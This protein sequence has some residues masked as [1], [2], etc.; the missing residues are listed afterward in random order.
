MDKGTALSR[1]E[2]LELVRQYKHIIARHFQQEPRVLMY[3]SYSKGNAN[4]DSD[5]DVAVVV[6]S[7]G[8]RK[9][10]LSKALWRDVD[11]VSLLIEPVLISEDHPSPLYDDVMRTGIAV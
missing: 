6:S 3:G 9:L 11:N 2:A 8:D 10:E 4:R 5:I 1:D 7:Y